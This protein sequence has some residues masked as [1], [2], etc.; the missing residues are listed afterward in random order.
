[1]KDAKIEI[2]KHLGFNPVFYSSEINSMDENER[3]SSY[4]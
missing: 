4:S 1:M 2:L 3:P